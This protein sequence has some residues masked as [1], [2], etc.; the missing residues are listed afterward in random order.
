M[1]KENYNNWINNENLNDETRNELSLLSE[2]ELQEAFY[3]DIEFG[4]AGMRGVMSPGTNK[5]NI[6]TITRASIGLAKYILNRYVDNQLVVIAYDSRNNSKK[7]AIQS[8]KVL[9]TFGI[10]VKVFDDIASTPVA[11]FAMRELNAC[12]GIVITASHNPKSDNGF[13]VYNQSGAQ[14]NLEESNQLIN[15]VL[16]SKEYLD[17]KLDENN[18]HLISPVSEDVTSAYQQNL[19]D[20]AVNEV[21]TSDCKYVFSP[22]FGTSWKFVQEAAKRREMNFIEVKSQVVP[23]GNFPG[24]TYPNPESKDAFKLGLE[25]ANVIEADSVFTTDPD[26]D[27]LGLAIAH[28]GEYVFLNGNEQ[29]ILAAVYLLNS[30]A[31]KNELN[32]KSLILSSIVS[33][34]LVEKIAS[35][36][37]CEFEKVL[38]GFKFIGE[39]IEKY[40]KDQSH[41]FVFG[42]EESY[43]CLVKDFA[44]DK[45]AL[46]ATMLFAEMIAYY[47]K[48]N[49]TL[50][51]VLN[52]T[53]QKFGF[54]KTSVLSY[55][56]EG[57]QG[58]TLMNKIMEKFREI[59]TIN[60]NEIEITEKVD[61][62][63][64]ETNLPSANVIEYHS[65]NKDKFV[66]LRPSGTE[67][68][69]KVYLEMI[70]ADE[71]QAQNEIDTITEVFN[72]IIENVNQPV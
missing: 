60:V 19:F 34:N 7:F 1:W 42:F 14:L 8:A 54:S 48:Q 5:I 10:E 15:F 65:E 51:D 9:A 64:Q 61:Y 67:P 4:T 68:K 21:D 40:N 41:E 50:V 11:S 31:S 16:D 71:N 70:N 62:L 32:E 58:I 3:K 56:F 47:K 24:L 72:R 69:L 27:R 55:S 28:K 6:Y 17:F 33:T 38:T 46:Q 53:Y 20:I 57:E 13:K 2:E 43:G 45:D 39:K 26:A 12:N 22:L 59:P 23:D 25:I 63:T 35:A 30:K 37:G 18:F 49:L 52:L 36:Y 66:F 29:G 44:R